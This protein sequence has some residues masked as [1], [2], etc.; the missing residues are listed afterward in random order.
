VKTVEEMYEATRGYEIRHGESF[1]DHFDSDFSQPSFMFWALG[2]GYL[3]TEKFDAWHDEYMK[4]YYCDCGDRLIYGDEEWSIVSDED[5][6]WE[7]PYKK[8]FMILAEFLAST[9][10][11]QNRV[12]E[13]LKENEEDDDDV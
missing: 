9:T 1:L 10:E 6:E 4:P 13:F 7:V 2:K 8:A 3:T 12:E 11:Y 5:V